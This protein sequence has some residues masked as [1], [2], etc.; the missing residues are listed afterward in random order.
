MFLHELN[1]PQRHAFMCLAARMASTDAQLH[2][3]ELAMLSQMRHEM[4]IPSSWRPSTA[5]TTALLAQFADHRS[6]TT[7]LLELLRLAR[8]DQAV[9]EEERLFFIE[10]ATAFGFSRA[11]VRSLLLWT[12]R[13]EALMVEAE[14]LMSASP[15]DMAPSG[16]DA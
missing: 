14:Q 16:I 2:D 15:R 1:D 8:C 4:D 3:L 7:V 11:Q 6:R 10:V 13:H 12:R 9:P 5:T